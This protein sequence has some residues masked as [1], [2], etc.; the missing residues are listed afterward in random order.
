MEKKYVMRLGP[1]RNPVLAQRALEAFYFL[2]A[3]KTFL[4]KMSILFRIRFGASPGK[5]ICI[6]I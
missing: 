3:G 2:K 1:D 4:A 6:T 5:A